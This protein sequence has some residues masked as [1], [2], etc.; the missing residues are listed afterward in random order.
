MLPCFRICLGKWDFTA[1][2][3]NRKCSVIVGTNDKVGKKCLFIHCFMWEHRRRMLI[4]TQPATQTWLAGF[5]FLEQWYRVGTEWLAC[6]TPTSWCGPAPKSPVH[7]RTERWI[8][9]PWDTEQQKQI[10]EALESIW[11]AVQPSCF[12]G[13]PRGY[14]SGIA[15]TV[16]GKGLELPR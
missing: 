1:P 5:Q 15:F 10:Q 14:A 8:G 6:L 2:T 7:Q 3:Y 9:K 4:M 13:D 16:P 11:P 12:F